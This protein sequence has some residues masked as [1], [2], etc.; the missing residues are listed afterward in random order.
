MFALDTLQKSIKSKDE[1]KCKNSYYQNI[2][3]NQNSNIVTKLLLATVV[4]CATLP[5]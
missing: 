5:Q 4:Y 2:V 1:K 3:N